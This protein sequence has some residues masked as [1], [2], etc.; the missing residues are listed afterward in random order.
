MFRWPGRFQNRSRPVIDS[1]AFCSVAMWILIRRIVSVCPAVLTLALLMLSLGACGGGS[2]APSLPP[3]PPAASNNPFWAQ[4]GSTPHSSRVSVRNCSR[5]T[6]ADSPVNAGDIERFPFRI[7]RVY[8]DDGRRTHQKG[9]LWRGFR[10][11]SRRFRPARRSGGFRA[12]PARAVARP[13]SPCGDRAHQRSGCA[14][15]PPSPGART[16]P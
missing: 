2:S 12:A 1:R 15:T 6:T 8:R 3:T 10:D 5:T 4:W 9:A 7:A 13:T 14:P 16:L 11:T